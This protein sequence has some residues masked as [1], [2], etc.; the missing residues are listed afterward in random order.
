LDALFGEDETVWFDG[1][2]F[3]VFLDIFAILLN[4]FKWAGVFEYE[5]EFACLRE[6][7][8]KKVFESMSIFILE[9]LFELF[10]NEFMGSG[11]HFEVEEIDNLVKNFLNFSLFNNKL[12]RGN[13]ILFSAID[14]G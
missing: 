13:I 4:Y 10:K 3:W 1:N 14:Q 2:F 12:G 7:G 8:N 9:A 11:L 5:I 6:K